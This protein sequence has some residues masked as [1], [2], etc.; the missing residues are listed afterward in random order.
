MKK[1]SKLL[2]ILSAS[3]SGST[4]LDLL[5]GTIPKVFSMGE[6]NF[7]SWQLLQGDIPS[8][9][10]TYCSCGSNFEKCEFYGSIFNEINEENNVNVFNKPKEYDFSI[11]RYI[12]RHKN[13]LHIR[14][15]NKILAYSLKYSI[16]KFLSYPVYWFYLPSIRRVW[17][18]F[19]KVSN[20]SKSEYVVDSS[21]DFLRYWLLK[22]H[23]PEDVKL[24]ILIR[25]LKGVASSSHYGLNQKLI[26]KRAKEYLLYYN[27]IIKPV[28]RFSE[29]YFMIVRYEELCQNPDIIRK[30]IV[31]FLNVEPIKEKLKFI[32]PYSYHTILGNPMRLVKNDIKIRYDERWK[33]RLNEDQKKELD[34]VSKRLN[35]FFQN[36]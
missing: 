19:D 5:S 4:L 35:P 33:E 15:I 2:Y 12:E 7:L 22:M 9:P 29:K 26:D 27:E 32:A 24:I 3:H 8:N 13:K 10:Q 18:L 25:D 20:K 31:K 17:D 23:R 1:K 6:V 11:N 34:L 30:Q 36:D 21:K 28:F 14:V 16:I